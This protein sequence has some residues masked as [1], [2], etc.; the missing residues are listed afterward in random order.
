[1]VNQDQVDFGSGILLIE[2]MSNHVRT[3]NLH[4]LYLYSEPQS[5]KQVN[6]LYLYLLSPNHV[7]TPRQR[8]SN[9]CIPVLRTIWAILR[10]QGLDITTCVCNLNLCTSIVSRKNIWLPVIWIVI[11]RAKT[12][13]WVNIKEL[14]KKISIKLNTILLNLDE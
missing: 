4:S 5:I 7:Q 8:L 1:M 2:I 10:P 12:W 9:C 11:Y 6:Y 3:S 13:G 14:R